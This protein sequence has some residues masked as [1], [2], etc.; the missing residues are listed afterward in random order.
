MLVSAGSTSWKASTD[1]EA[2]STRPI[3]QPGSW[4]DTC[5]QATLA[6]A[7]PADR[8]PAPLDDAERFAAHL[9]SEFPAI[10][11]FLWDPSV[12]A[13]NWRAEQTAAAQ[14]VNRYLNSARGK[15]KPRLDENLAPSTLAG[16]TLP[17][18][19]GQGMGELPPPN[20][21]ITD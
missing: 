6:G 8:Q 13:T 1:S 12:D 18:V 17:F 11:T 21:Y 15:Y 20:G 2:A 4:S 7:Q 14:G 16:K 9:A 19:P 5:S 3:V 10:F